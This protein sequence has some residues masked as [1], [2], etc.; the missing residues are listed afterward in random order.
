MKMDDNQFLQAVL[1][2]SKIALASSQ[3]KILLMAF[4][5]PT[6]EAKKAGKAR[7]RAEE[8]IKPQGLRKIT[9]KFVKQ[10]H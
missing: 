2:A 9:Q 6:A 3:P 4:I 8:T 7:R 5:A 1:A 10:G